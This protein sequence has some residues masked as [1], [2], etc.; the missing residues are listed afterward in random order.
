MKNKNLN[1]C[2]KNKNLNTC[3]KN[4]N[5]NNCMKN[6]Q[7]NTCMKNHLEILIPATKPKVAFYKKNG[8]KKLTMQNPLFSKNIY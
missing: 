2:M 3:M 4:K 6:N 1:T 5:L 8:E 7:L